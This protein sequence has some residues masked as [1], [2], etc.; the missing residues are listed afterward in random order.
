[1]TVFLGCF[2]TCAFSPI[3]EMKDDK[4]RVHKRFRVLVKKKDP[5]SN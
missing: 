4:N 5:G 1:M 2:L 3:A